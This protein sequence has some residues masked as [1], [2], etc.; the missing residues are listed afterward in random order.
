MKR[1]DYVFS[2]YRNAVTS[3]SSHNTQRV[4]IVR[5]V[6]GL[7]QRTLQPT[8]GAVA[9]AT[10]RRLIDLSIRNMCTKS[11]KK[12]LWLLTLFPTSP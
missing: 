11:P 4:P 7:A 6:A 1:E 10:P 9:W 8:L 12:S 5:T 2:I 3:S